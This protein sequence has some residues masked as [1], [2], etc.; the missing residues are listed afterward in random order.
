MALPGVEM[1]TVDTDGIKWR[2]IKRP[3]RIAKDVAQTKMRQLKNIQ[4]QLEK[5]LRE[6]IHDLPEIST[7]ACRGPLSRF[8]YIDDC[9][10]KV[11]VVQ[12]PSEEQLEDAALTGCGPPATTKFLHDEQ[13]Q[14]C[15][16]VQ[17]RKCN[18]YYTAYG[19]DWI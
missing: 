17:C 8:L 12:Q 5:D 13:L 15:S 6:I 3:P 1:T 19:F 2:K 4:I 9:M 16:Y 7:D 18:N 14:N 11:S 10:F